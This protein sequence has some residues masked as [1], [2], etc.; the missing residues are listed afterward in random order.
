MLGTNNLGTS[1]TKTG[2]ICGPWSFGIVAN[3]PNSPLVH[4]QISSIRAQ[5]LSEFE[6][7]IVSSQKPEDKKVK[8]VPFP[9]ELGTNWITRKKNFLAQ[10][11]RHENLVVMHD[12]IGLHKDWAAGFEIFGNSWNIALTRVEDIAGRRFYDWAAWD[13]VIY[14]RYAPIPYSKKDHT[15][16]QFIPG[17][18][19]VVKTQFMLDYPLNEKLSWGQSEDVEWSLRVREKG[20]V[21]NSYSKVCHLKKH[22]GFKF[23]RSINNDGLQIYPR[24]DFLNWEQ[25]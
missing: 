2:V 15:S 6:I 25:I 9:E 10:N 16:Y 14:P 22:R 11:A 7:L 21:F 20:L 23:Y 1:I 5:G 4:R 24:P 8:W 12:Y 17:A 19:W 13:S 3:N 18:Y